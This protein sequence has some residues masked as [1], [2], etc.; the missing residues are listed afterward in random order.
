VWS[1]FLAEGMG[2]GASCS[3]HYFELRDGIAASAWYTQGVRFLD[4]RDPANPIQIAYFRPLDANA[5]APYFR[6]DHVFIADGTRGIDII[7]LTAEA[8]AARRT[9]TPVLAPPPTA[10]G[11]RLQAATLARYRPDPVMGWSCRL[12]ATG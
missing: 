7:R 11:L 4:V 1:P 2:V 6:G 8:E 12:P 9:R 3:A 10:E 5:W